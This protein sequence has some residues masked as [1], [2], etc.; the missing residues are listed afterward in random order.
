[1]KTGLVLSGG[2]ARGFAHIGVLQTLKE[3][4]ISVDAISGCSIGALIG[5]CYSY[6]QDPIKI[7]NLLTNLN[8]NKN[9]N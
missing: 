5:A 9:I 1:M 6:D 2:G 8:S 3:N 4:R 7:K